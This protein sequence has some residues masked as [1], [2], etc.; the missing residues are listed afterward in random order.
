[1]ISINFIEEKLL[2]LH[3][4]LLIERKYRKPWQLFKEISFGVLKGYFFLAVAVCRIWAATFHSI[5]YKKFIKIVNNILY[6]RRYS[7][8]SNQGNKKNSSVTKNG[9]KKKIK[10][11]PTKVEKKP[12][13]KNSELPNDILQN[14]EDLRKLLKKIAEETTDPYED[15]TQFP[16]NPWEKKN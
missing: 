4:D 10:K 16:K 12:T 13:E 5:V 14:I 8:V 3:G 15:N 9:V 2:H 6:G 7:S 11:L 1:M